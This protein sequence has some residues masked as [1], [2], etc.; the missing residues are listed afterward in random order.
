M[1]C[2][3]Q[4]YFIQNFENSILSLSTFSSLQNVHVAVLSRWV[5]LWEIATIWNDS[6]FFPNNTKLEAI[7]LGRRPLTSRQMA[8]LETWIFRTTC[9]RPYLFP[10]MVASF[11]EFLLCSWFP[12]SIL[13]PLRNQRCFL[14]LLTIQLQ[15]WHFKES[16]L[17]RGNEEGQFFQTWGY[18]RLRSTRV[19]I[20]TWKSAYVHEQSNW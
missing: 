11:P 8:I 18:L 15:I 17:W 2:I 5:Q 4:S 12:H 16:Q 7:L 10:A 1:G 14:C 3:I 9:H 6:L 20:Y 19:E 13:V